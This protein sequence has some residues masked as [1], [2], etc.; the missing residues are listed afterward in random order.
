[1]ARKWTAE[2]KARHSELIH[3]WKP[4]EK[5]TGA[6][7]PEGKKRASQNRAIALNKARQK[8]ADLATQLQQAQSELIRQTAG[9]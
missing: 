9:R 6:K 1:M 7:T 2:Q 8:I 4:W 5:S 3:H